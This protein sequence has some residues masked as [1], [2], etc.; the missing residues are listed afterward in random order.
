LPVIKHFTQKS[1][2]LF[3]KNPR[4]HKPRSGGTEGGFWTP[5]YGMFVSKSR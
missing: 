4:L 2:A 1:A 5:G 3:R